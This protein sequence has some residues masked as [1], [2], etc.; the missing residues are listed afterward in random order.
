[1]V[2]AGAIEPDIAQHCAEALNRPDVLSLGYVNDVPSVFRSADIFAFPSLEEG[3]PLVMYE[4]CGRGIS[5]ILS[6]MAAGE[7]ARDGQEAIVREPYDQDAWIDALRQLAKD[8]ELRHHLGN[9]ARQ[10]A[11]NYTW[12]HVANRRKNMLL[13]ATG[14]HEHATAETMAN[15]S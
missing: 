6:P 10:R 11:Q 3:S 2:L 1:L 13:Q 5:S 4:A 9:A 14:K 7:I 15:T 12:A 8:T